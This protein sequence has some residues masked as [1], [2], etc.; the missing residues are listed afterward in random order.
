M[1]ARSSSSI[2]LPPAR[3]ASTVRGAQT[4]PNR[5]PSSEDSDLD[6]Y[7]SKFLLLYIIEICATCGY[8]LES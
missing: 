3:L 1:H 2:F 6:P 8:G 4:P 7:H 5:R